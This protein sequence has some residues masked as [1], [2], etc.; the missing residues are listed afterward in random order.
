MIGHAPV[1]SL[2]HLPSIQPVGNGNRLGTIRVIDAIVLTKGEDGT[3][4]LTELAATPPRSESF[5]P[6]G[7]L[8]RRSSRPSRR[9]AYLRPR[10]LKVPLRR[11]RVGRVGVIGA[12]GRTSCRGGRR[13]DTWPFARSEDRG[14]GRCGHARKAPADLAKPS[15]RVSGGSSALITMQL[16]DRRRT[17]PASRRGGDPCPSPDLP[18]C[19][20]AF[21]TNARGIAPVGRI[22]DVA[23]AVDRDLMDAVDRVY[24]DVPWEL[25]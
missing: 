24:A 7:S 5:R 1:G 23:A 13:R 15:G 22:D 9:M 3:A 19:S 8:S 6:F 14:G 17:A 16:V 25:C 2:A 12:P 11:A 21:V 4:E 10:R 20:A 18:S